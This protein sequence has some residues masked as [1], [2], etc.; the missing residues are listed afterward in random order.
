MNQTQITRSL[1]AYLLWLFGK[2]MFTETHQDTIT[3]RW[4]PVA[5]EIAEAQMEDDIT[6]RS[7]GSAVLAATYRA[8]CNA[9]VKSK[10]TSSLL[11]CPLLLHLWSWE[12]FPV[13][14]P[15][16]DA[17][18]PWDYRLMDHT[19]V[20]APTFGSTWAQREV[21]GLLYSVMYCVIFR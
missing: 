5:Q 6:P 3:A 19:E 9:C 1:E 21:N 13:G 18:I 12:R 11:G 8:M 15:D 16:V 2:V 20:D 17:H 4:I 7:F 10:E 14:R